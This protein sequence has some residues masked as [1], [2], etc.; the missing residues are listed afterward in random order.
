MQHVTQSWP[1]LQAT[2]IVLTSWT[3]EFMPCHEPVP[4]GF[5]YLSQPGPHNHWL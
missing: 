2:K 1:M 3:T 5:L 4:A